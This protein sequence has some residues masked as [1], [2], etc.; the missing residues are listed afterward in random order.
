M[1]FSGKA[2][3]NKDRSS[4]VKIRM[5]GKKFRMSYNCFYSSFEY[6]AEDYFPSSSTL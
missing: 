4:F 5:T 1:I 2:V 6:F 3:N